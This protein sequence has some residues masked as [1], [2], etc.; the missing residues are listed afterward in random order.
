MKLIREL[1]EDVDVLIQEDT[2]GQKDYYITGP[3]LVCEQK[4]RNGRIYPAH[5]MEKEVNRYIAEMV[6][7][8]RALGEL[9]HPESPRIDLERASHLITELKKDGNVYYGKAKVLDTPMGKIAKGLLAGGVKIGISSRGMGSLKNVNGI[10]IVQDDYVICTAG[11]IVSDP[12]GPGCFV[13]GIMESA[14]WIVENG[15]WKPQ[16][17]EEAQKQIRKAS[18]KDIEAVAIQIFE[19]YF[20]NL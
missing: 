15:V 5:V 6:D 12:S 11:D 17:V 2:N 14:D 19:N 18:S 3:F 4:N 1:V 16:F 13:D 10:N 20:K 7:T 9:N 8:K